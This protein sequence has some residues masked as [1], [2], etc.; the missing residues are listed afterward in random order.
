MNID[1]LVN[2]AVC[3]SAYGSGTSAVGVSRGKS[4]G[5][6]GNQSISDVKFMEN[7]LNRHTKA[8]TEKSRTQKKIRFT[9]ERMKSTYVHVVPSAP[10]QNYPIHQKL[11][12]KLA[13]MTTTCQQYRDIPLSGR[14]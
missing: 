4:N 8:D 1:W 6:T 13:Q 9:T 7:I 5:G 10:L 3:P 14:L 2:Y 11:G 12:S